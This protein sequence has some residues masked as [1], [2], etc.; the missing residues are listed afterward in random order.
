V[1]GC[2]QAGSQEQGTTAR[3]SAELVRGGWEASTR[4]QAQRA[5]GGHPPAHL[6]D[7]GDSAATHGV[8]DGPTGT[9]IP[10]LT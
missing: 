7:P 5:C 1:A 6:C 8:A 9:G 2:A 10:W 3:E 4:T